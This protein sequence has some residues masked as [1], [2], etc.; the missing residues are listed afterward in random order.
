MFSTVN[1]AGRFFFF[2]DQGCKIGVR[3]QY[4]PQLSL[5]N[6][7]KIDYDSL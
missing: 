7:A 6:T 4:P 1:L 3:S 2:Y 5:E